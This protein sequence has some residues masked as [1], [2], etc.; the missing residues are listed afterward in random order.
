MTTRSVLFRHRSIAGLVHDPLAD[1]PDDTWGDTEGVI[2]AART[3]GHGT[4]SR[5]VL[6]VTDDRG[7][8]VV[9]TLD[10]NRVRQTPDFLRTRGARVQIRGTVRRL[11]GLPPTIT[12][13]GIA[14]AA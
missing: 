3:F 6:N 2:T 11:P 12:A 10:S 4:N 7:A 14:P 9:V 1:V 13:T 8:T 5:V